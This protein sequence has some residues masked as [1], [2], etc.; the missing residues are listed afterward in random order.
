VGEFSQKQLDV[1]GRDRVFLDRVKTD[2]LL[3]RLFSEKDQDRDDEITELI[4][5]MGG[6][7]VLKSSNRRVKE[8]RFKAPTIGVISM[9]GIIKTPFLPERKNPSLMDINRALYLLMSQEEAFASCQNIDSDLD[10]KCVGLCEKLGLDYNEVAVVIHDVIEGSFSALK[11]LPEQLADEKRLY[12]DTFWATS[13]IAQTAPY[14]GLPF[15]E[16]RWR[17]PLITVLFF[18]VQNLRLNG[19]K[20]IM[21]RTKAGDCKN[22]LDELMRKR[23]EELKCQK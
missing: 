16:I 19:M 7:I 13:L 12:W 23:L 9:L 6:D 3:N 5:S 11:M 20:G 4:L 22:R 8:V 18:Y 2:A 17:V 21:R 15:E 14:I 10:P 1:I